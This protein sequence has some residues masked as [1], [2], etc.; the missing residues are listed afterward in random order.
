M[1]WNYEDFIKKY[2]NAAELMEFAEKHPVGVDTNDLSYFINGHSCTSAC[3]DAIKELTK[4][5]QIYI[6][7]FQQLTPHQQQ[8]FFL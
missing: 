1:K 7:I 5:E 3:L 4:P 8:E 2:I 6:F